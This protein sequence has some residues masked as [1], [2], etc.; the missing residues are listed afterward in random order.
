MVAVTGLGKLPAQLLNDA[1]RVDLEPR[2]K[3]RQPVLLDDGL[4]RRLNGG[5]VF[6]VACHCASLPKS[7]WGARGRTSAACLEWSGWRAHRVGDADRRARFQSRV[8]ATAVSDPVFVAALCGLASR[9]GVR[10]G[11]LELPALTC[12]SGR[13]FSPP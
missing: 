10:C 11:A 5:P 7:V 3:Q 12:H 9:L 8:L 13:I 6:S 2:R 1:G 4:R